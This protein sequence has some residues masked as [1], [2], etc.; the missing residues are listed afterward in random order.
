[1]LVTEG[2]SRAYTGEFASCVWLSLAVLLC[3]LP[4][5]CGT[6]AQSRG[7]YP[8]GTSATN[9]GVTPKP[10]FTYSNQLLFYSRSEIED[11]KGATLPIAGAI[12]S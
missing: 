12:P 4:L 7:V 3:I 1:M 9:S 2:I 5:V 11:K 10:G 8:V 6:Q